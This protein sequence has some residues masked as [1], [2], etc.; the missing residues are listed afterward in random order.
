MNLLFLKGASMGRKK[1]NT[2]T[3]INRYTVQMDEG[4]Y[5]AVKRAAIGLK[6]NGGTTDGVK[7]YELMN[8]VILLGLEAWS[9]AQKNPKAKVN[10]REAVFAKAREMARQIP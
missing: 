1:E 3:N 5:M 8:K 10:I 7:T 2:P 6:K 9:K 4:V